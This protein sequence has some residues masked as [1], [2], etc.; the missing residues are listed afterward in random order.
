M[1]QSYIVQR[2]ELANMYDGGGSTVPE[3][4]HWNLVF[5][6]KLEI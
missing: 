1:Q 6:Q 3:G 2:E 4:E 5:I